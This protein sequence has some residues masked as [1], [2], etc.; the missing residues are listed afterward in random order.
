M[1][2]GYR[3]AQLRAIFDLLPILQDLCP[4]SAS[5][6]PHLAYLELFT[7]FTSRPERYTRLY[8]VARSYLGL[9]RRAIVVPLD[10]IYRSCHLLP[11]FGKE[12][13]KDWTSDSMLETCNTFF[14]N[15][16]S[17]IHMYVFV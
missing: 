15:P 14:L 7:P 3:I 5:A 4:A 13:N 17:D 12:A 8:K 16:F 6:R 9:E 10:K 2:P 11:D 1:P